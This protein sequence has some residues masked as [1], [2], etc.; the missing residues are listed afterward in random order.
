[1]KRQT[2]TVQDAAVISDNIL[3]KKKPVSNISKVKY[4]RQ[5]ERP[6]KSR[7]KKE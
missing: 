5:K 2:I 3:V 6:T 4:G 1:M 7:R